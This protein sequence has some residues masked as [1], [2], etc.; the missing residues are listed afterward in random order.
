VSARSPRAL[1]ELC[2]RWADVLDAPNASD[3][4]A[5]HAWTAGNRRAHDRYRVAFVDRTAAALADQARTYASGGCDAEPAGNRRPKMAFVFSGHGSQW[6]RMGSDLY[7]DEPVYRA[8]IDECDH[9]LG[10]RTDW[11]L[12]AELAAPEGRTR[13]DGMNRADIIQPAIF[14][15]QVGLASL[16]G[17]WGVR[18]DAVLGHSLGEV[19]AAHIAGALTLDEA[20]EVVTVRSRLAENVSPGLGMAVIDLPLG[21]V[22][23]MVAPYGERLGVAAVNS[24]SS[25][26]VGGDRQA[27]AE[28]IA[29]C[30]RQGATARP[31][32][33]E[34]AT[35][36]P[37]VDPVLPVLREALAGLRP[38]PAS[39]PFLSSVEGMTPERATLDAGYWAHNLRRTVRFDDALG[40]A[41]REGITIF[42]EISPR[43][44]LLRA[45]RDTAESLQASLTGLPSFTRGPYGPSVV[46]RAAADLW[47]RGCR[48]DW[49][50]LQGRRRRVTKAPTYPWQRSRY[51]IEADGVREPGAS[52]STAPGA[53]V[54]APPA[55]SDRVPGPR[56]YATEWRPAGPPGQDGSPAAEWLVVRGT[57][58]AGHPVLTAAGRQ[59]L[60]TCSPDQVPEALSQAYGP[61]GNQRLRILY[62]SA[63]GLDG[64]DLDDPRA[65]QTLATAAG[66]LVTLLN[67]I[68]S[69]SGEPPVQVTVATRGAFDAGGDPGANVAAAHLVGLA[70]TLRLEHPE[71]EFAVVD[72]PASGTDLDLRGALAGGHG[73]REL[74]IRDGSALARRIVPSD[75]PQRG[76]PFG[77]DGAG[78]YLITGG[79][80][81]VG[82]AVAQW[83]AGSGARSL[84]LASRSGTGPPA[85]DAAVA[86]L[87]AAGVHVA[88][89]SVDVSDRRAV[90]ALVG[91]IHDP[92]APLRGVFHAAGVLDDA[93]ATELTAARFARTLAAKVSGT[94]NLH[95]ATMDLGLEHFVMFSSL[96]SVLG[97]PGQANY[98]AAN[99]AMDAIARLRRHAGLPAVSVSWG[100]WAEIGGA[101]PQ[102][103]WTDF[104]RRFGIRASPPADLL[105][106]LGESM[107]TGITH[108]A[109][110]DGDT[111]VLASSLEWSNPHLLSELAPRSGRTPPNGPRSD[112]RW[113]AA[114]AA[115]DGAE[116][117]ALLV[118]C[119]LAE[120]SAALRVRIADLDADAA[121]STMGLD[122][123]TALEVSACAQRETGVPLTP[124]TVIE[125][126]SISSLAEFLD[127][128]IARCPAVDGTADD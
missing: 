92:A 80:G 32:R 98:A 20:A 51:W 16:L 53:Q 86:S 41:V 70:R 11:S 57:G 14:A 83:L 112:A 10:K 48:V 126:P 107:E 74:A 120:V 119:L 40:V 77:I 33:V 6:T 72:L 115:G 95:L 68:I 71:L 58:A 85:A 21:P 31:I 38:S 91:E 36:C 88:V 67:A 52:Q 66:D 121:W 113:A 109:A 12:C 114:L 26:T 5:D 9:A 69:R 127:Q 30:E 43:P 23:D 47:E 7:R 122:S 63:P 42:V 24:P 96:A 124:R 99:A 81:G 93:M 28:L 39:T 61:D 64:V 62:A 116:R 46:R 8:A 102:R 37:A 29:A 106:L 101:A 103:T 125:C 13:M 111:A 2:L 73:E 34:G 94:W 82:L 105:D 54:S 35:H 110:I 108:A 128:R 15:M 50:S 104:L 44:I 79:T 4:V 76:R 59:G 25:T 78:T 18:P 55:D 97:S 19:A 49:P 100:P 89:R 22:A 1:H 60:R 90:Q 117:R 65:A 3:N 118:D 75:G 84:V 123:V 87:R 45:I 56:L 17:H 27:I